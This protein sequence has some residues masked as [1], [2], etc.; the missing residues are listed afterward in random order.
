MFFD[1]CLFNFI[2]IQVLV[3]QCSACTLK[4]KQGIELLMLVECGEGDLWWVVGV[5]NLFSSGEG[6]NLPPKHLDHKTGILNA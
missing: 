6:A 3:L 5:V 2:N 1:I 4:L